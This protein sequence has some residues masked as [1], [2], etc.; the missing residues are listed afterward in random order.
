MQKVEKRMEKQ[1]HLVKA[2]AMPLCP[3]ADAT[4]KNK[5]D[6]P[7]LEGLRLRNSISSR[8]RSLRFERENAVYDE[9]GLGSLRKENSEEVIQ[10]CISIHSAATYVSTDNEDDVS[11]IPSAWS[12][13]VLGLGVRF[14]PNCSL[15][16]GS[17]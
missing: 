10:R 4:K 11:P 17:T 3:F 13:V 9:R 8:P 2:R 14:V 15:P 1:F 5:T 7:D 12:P 16:L 6:A